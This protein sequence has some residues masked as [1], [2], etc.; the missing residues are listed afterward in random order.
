M[1]F[2]YCIIIVNHYFN[3][4]HVYVVGAGVGVAAK[5]V[6]EDLKLDVWE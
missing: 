3:F 6:E 4:K 2:K 5:A 1:H